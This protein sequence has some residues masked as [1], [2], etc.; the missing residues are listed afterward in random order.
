MVTVQCFTATAAAAIR[1]V[2]A[3]KCNKSDVSW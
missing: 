1:A 3:K 2:T